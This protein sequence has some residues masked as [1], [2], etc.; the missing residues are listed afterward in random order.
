MAQPEPNPEVSPEARALLDGSVWSQFCRMLEQ[1][2]AVVM[3][4]SA[5]NDLRTRA[6]GFRYLSRIA[7]A[8]LEA[9]VEF[10]DPRAPVLRRTIDETKKM[11]SDN[12]DN[13]YLNAE[14][15]GIYEYRITGQRGTVDYLAFATQ[16]GGYG[17]GRGLPPTGMIEASQLDIGPDGR[18]ELRLSCAPQPGNWLPMEPDT[19]LLIVRQ[20]FLDRANERPAELTI[21]R[22]PAPDEPSV[23]DGITPEQLVTGMR[24]AGMLVGGAAALFANWAEGFRKR[25]NELPQFD[26]KVSLMA[27]GDPTIAYYHGYW[28]L[29]PAQALVIEIEPPVCQTWNFQLNNWWMESLDYRRHPIVINKHSAVPDADGTVRIVVA[30]EN[31]GVANWISTT[32]LPQGT[33]CLRWVRAE[34]HPQPRTRVV[35]LASLRA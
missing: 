26:P 34:T 32:G 30:H 19:G 22:I 13:H 27:G 23:D 3:R 35:E 33:M 21:E 20:T 2:G 6:E 18:F 7:R 25:P 11:G 10:A 5:P 14:I 24:R 1:A 16:K 17:E 29:G 31:P 9:F 8:G 12:P 28:E 4:E 15:R